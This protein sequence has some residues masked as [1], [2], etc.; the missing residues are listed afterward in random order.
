MKQLLL[1]LLALSMTSLLARAEGD[2]KDT[3]RIDVG[4]PRM[5]HLRSN[6]LHDVLLVPNLGVE[7]PVARRFTLVA[8]GSLGWWRIEQKH[9]YWRMATGQIELRYWK[10]WT[11]NAFRYRGHH[12]GVYG[13]L[14]RYDF[15]FG[16]TGYQADLNYGAGFSWG[17]A[18]RLNRCLSLDLSVGVGYI[19]GKYHKYEPYRGRYQQ[20][21]TVSRHYF[22]PSKLEATLVWHIEMG[23]GGAGL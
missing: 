2:W 13:A 12:F 22:G 18:A 19:G 10:N 23:K 14:Y 17:Y 20:L 15:E 6:L 11:T 1:I 5:F 16:S 9:R 8:D 3:V 21:S 7:W 4:H